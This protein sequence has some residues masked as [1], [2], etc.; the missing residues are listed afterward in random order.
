RREFLAAGAQRGQVYA[1]A[2]AAFEDH[3]F[4]A[5]P[6][7]DRV[8]A[9]LDLEDEACGTLRLGLDADV[10]IDRAVE[11]GLLVEEQVLELGVEGFALV[12]AGKVALLLA[13]SGDGI[14]DARDE[15]AHAGLA[16]RRSE[17]AAKIF[18]YHDVGR[19]L[20]P[21]ARH[22][23]V[24]LLEDYAAV[25]ARDDG[26]AE[27]PFDFG[28]WIDAGGGE[29]ALEHDTATGRDR[30]GRRSVGGWCAVGYF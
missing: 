23:D 4:V 2:G 12:G 25:F 8:H 17:R 20:R 19:G 11:R 3:A 26:A 27:I 30:I 13:P 5:V 21:S 24:F 14:D 9:V 1:R 28:I 16:P 18:R 15:L 6:A 10:E 7:Q 29:E 22:L